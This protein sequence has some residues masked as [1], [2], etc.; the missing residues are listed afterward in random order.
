[1]TNK[2]KYLKDNVSVEEF[3]KSIAK[4]LYIDKEFLYSQNDYTKIKEWTK[5]KI[6]PTLTEDER[7]ILRNIDKAYRYIHREY[8]NLRVS[9]EE[10]GLE[11][12]SFDMYDSLFQF[13]KERRRIRDKEIVK[14]VNIW[15]VGFIH[16]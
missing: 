15:E 8:G 12:E 14:G 9:L 2:D 3:A 4:Y 1:M 16:K 11:S 5:N 6:M 10:K 13:I 7:V